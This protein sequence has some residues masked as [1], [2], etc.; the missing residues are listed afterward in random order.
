MINDDGYVYVPNVDVYEWNGHKNSLP[1]LNYAR[2][3]HACAGYYNWR[4]NFVGYECIKNS[5]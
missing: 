3:G 4:G 5:I 2:R 1:N